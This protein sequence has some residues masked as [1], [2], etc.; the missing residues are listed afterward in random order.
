MFRTSLVSNVVSLCRDEN[1]KISAKKATAAVQENA[2]NM[3]TLPAILLVK[4]PRFLIVA[5][6]CIARSFQ[7][8]IIF[9]F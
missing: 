4:T 3:Q 5:S 7:T 2:R 1:A 8:I 6:S 9:F